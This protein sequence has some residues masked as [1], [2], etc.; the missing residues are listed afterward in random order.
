M[1]KRYRAGSREMPR[2]PPTSALSRGTPGA[3]QTS[4]GAVPPGKGAPVRAYGPMGSLLARE[5]ASRGRGCCQATAA[6]GR[7][8]G[9]EWGCW[10]GRSGRP[11]AGGHGNHS[12][13]GPCLRG[14]GA[15]LGS[16]CHGHLR[17]G[18]PSVP[19][20]VPL[21]MK[22]APRGG[23]G[24]LPGGDPLPPALHRPPWLY[25]SVD[26]SCPRAGGSRGWG[27][28]MWLCGAP[29]CP[30]PGGPGSETLG[31]SPRDLGR[32]SRVTLGV[33]TG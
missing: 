26:R 13:V 3:L 15:D 28:R 4:L 10:R 17:P 21:N 20:S 30:G 25:P 16:P 31:V 27:L 22:V 19:T 23:P 12:V 9:A 8:R 5:E 24:A 1:E 33:L 14:F 2:A 32:P 6:G 29:P 18:P 11:A 7:L